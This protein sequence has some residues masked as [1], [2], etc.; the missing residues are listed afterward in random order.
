[1]KKIFVIILSAILIA[2]IGAISVGIWIISNNSLQT[3][4]VNSLLKNSHASISS[5]NLSLKKID[6]E[7]FKIE[8]EKGIFTA[9]KF[10]LQYKFFTLLTGKIKGEGSLKN[11]VFTLVDSPTKAQ[12]ECVKQ[13]KVSQEL[14]SLPP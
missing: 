3:D 9:E 7:N 10:S 14:S 8:T 5:A 1:M 12:E 11:A 6:I 2:I 13:T 4:I